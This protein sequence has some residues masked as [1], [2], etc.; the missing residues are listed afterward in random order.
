MCAV[1]EV[2]DSV[3]CALASRT[4]KAINL[5]AY[6]VSGYDPTGE[7]IVVQIPQRLYYTDPQ[8]IP[9]YVVKLFL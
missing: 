7:Y 3:L 6:S 5:L 9:L 8:A 1:D 4:V 2:H